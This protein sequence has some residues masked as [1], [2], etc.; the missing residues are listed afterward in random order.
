MA[1]KPISIRQMEK[2]TVDV[3]EAVVIMTQRA[4]QIAQN[5]VTQK[6]IN[7]MED[8]ESD[9]IDLMAEE[10]DQAYEE[11]EKS[12]TVAISEFMEGDLSWRDI[13]ED[14]PIEF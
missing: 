1:V 13:S 14:A 10:E 6:L 12:T 7:E 4:K 8:Y 9:T 11:Q 3:Y 2:Q 5:R